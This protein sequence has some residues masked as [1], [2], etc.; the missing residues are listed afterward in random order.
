MSH[1][2]GIDLGTTIAR[3]AVVEDGRPVVIPDSEGRRATPSI[4]TLIDGRA[5]HLIGQPAKRQ[6]IANPEDTLSM[7]KRIIG[8]KFGSEA[9]AHTRGRVPF[10]L[11]ETENGATCL[12]VRGRKYAPAEISSF[13]LM[14]LKRI[15]ED[16]LGQE[17]TQAVITCPAAFDDAQRQATK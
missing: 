14:K 1:V 5:D 17:I 16:Y 10:E 4:V 15:A 2:I 8:R 13:V 3:V 6:S 7:V 12:E 9:I 11:A